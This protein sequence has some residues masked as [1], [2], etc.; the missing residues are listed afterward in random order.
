MLRDFNANSRRHSAASRNPIITTKHTKSTKKIHPDGLIQ[1]HIA[2][3]RRGAGDGAGRQ[4]Q[5]PSST[6]SLWRD[7][8]LQNV[9]E[10]RVWTALLHHYYIY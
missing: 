8:G 7:E 4:G 1:P 9:K 10:Q 5:P 2:T 3:R 6:A